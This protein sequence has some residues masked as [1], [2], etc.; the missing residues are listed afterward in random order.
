[1]PVES[2]SSLGV[3]V[4][5]ENITR[6]IEISGVMHYDVLRRF[7]ERDG[8]EVLRLNAYAA[9]DDEA[10]ERRKKGK[11]QWF[12]QIRQFG[13]KVVEKKVKW[14]VDQVTNTKVSKAN[15]DLELAVDALI[16]SEKLDRVL[17]VTGDGDFV[18][19]VRALQNRGC[20]VEV[21]GFSN[22]S[23]ELRRE[24]DLFISGY[25]VPDLITRKQGTP[26]W[27]KPGSTVRGICY[28]YDQERRYGFFRYLETISSGLWITDARNAESPYKTAFVLE[29]EVAKAIDVGRLP[30]YSKHIFSFRLDK[31]DKEGGNLQA[32]DVQLVCSY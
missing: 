17:L 7:A 16:Q 13:Y 3:Y 26:P 23:S 30:S 5:S 22:V 29:D 24:A 11:I 2:R 12:D 28:N 10:D 6:C 14:F 15:A 1:M 8:A 31:P 32:R 25:L 27:G 18:R 4:D 9:F 19:V 21:L 20:R